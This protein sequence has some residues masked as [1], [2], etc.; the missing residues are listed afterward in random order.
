MNKVLRTIPLFTIL[1]LVA[2]PAFAENM[3]L[4]QVL[5]TVL[6][7][8]PSLRTGD[9]DSAIARTESQRIAGMLEIGRAH[10]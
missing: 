1:L 4:K 2:Y 7:N 8:H 3:T 9:I 5:E 10:V 6:S